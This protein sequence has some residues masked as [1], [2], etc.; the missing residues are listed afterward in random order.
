MLLI[1][2]KI[3]AETSQVCT[4]LMETP[5]GKIA[6]YGDVTADVKTF[7]RLKWTRQ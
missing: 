1:S 3:F 7:V 6:V 2:S 5:S 4:K